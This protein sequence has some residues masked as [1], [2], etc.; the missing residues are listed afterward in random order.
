MTDPILAYG[1]IVLGLFLLFA[2]FVFPTLGVLFVMGIGALIAGIA[3]SFYGDPTRGLVTV[4]GVFVL[5]AILGPLM[6]KYWPRTALGRKFFLE[7]P[8]EDATV[9]AMPTNLELEQLRGRYGKT[10]SSLRPSGVT[11]F[12]GKRVDTI[13]DGEMI[14]PG[15]WVRCIDVRS[16]R[17]VV[18]QAEKPVDLGDLTPEDLRG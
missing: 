1:L 17:V 9:A 12:D 13:T 2:E 15:Q 6:I 3:M 11:E 14:D 18:R 5:I 7:R 4:V 8:D 16:G 10:I